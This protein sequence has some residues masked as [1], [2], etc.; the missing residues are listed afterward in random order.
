[1][2]T[3]LLILILTIIS[4]VNSE[5]IGC[6]KKEDCTCTQN[7]ACIINCI[8]KDQCK[9]SSVDLTCKSNQPCTINCLGEAAC[10]DARLWGNGASSFTVRC[11]GKDV[12]KG[13]NG[14]I[15]CA[16]GADC[17]ITCIDNGGGSG[18]GDTDFD[19]NNARSFQCSGGDCPNVDTYS[20]DPTPAPTQQPTPSP[21]PAPT[22]NPTP[23][24]TKNPTPS[25]T[26]APTKN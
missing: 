6:G 1:M 21:T 3:L 25:P 8:G 9:D 11:E 13:G 2:A 23:S 19:T 14:V 26:P 16:S 5:T 22:K 15:E 7:N 20:P 12:C 18:C 24:P 4:T 10:G 17:T